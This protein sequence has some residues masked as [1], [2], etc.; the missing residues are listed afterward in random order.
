MQVTESDQRLSGRHWLWFASWV[1]V[2]AVFAV[3][4]DIFFLL[5]VAGL[6]AV[7]L[8]RDDGRKRAAWGAVTGFGVPFLWVAHIHSNN[9]SGWQ[10]LLAGIAL[11]VTGVVADMSGWGFQ[12]AKAR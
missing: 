3:A 10:W 2:G 8:F 1:L 11:I 12:R 7:P 9:A 4:L 6:V 5:P